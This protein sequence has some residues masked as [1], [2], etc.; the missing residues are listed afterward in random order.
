LP[1]GRKTWL[2][3]STVEFLLEIKPQLL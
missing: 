1:K 3:A 2:P